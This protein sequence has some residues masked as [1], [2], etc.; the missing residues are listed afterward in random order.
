MTCSRKMHWIMTMLAI[1]MFLSAHILGSQN[2]PVIR[3]SVENTASHVQTQ[4]VQRFS[5]A[6]RE[7]LAGSYDV[8]F[9]PAA[10]LFRDADVFRAL[11]Q[12]KV[13]IA[14]PG[15]WQ[16]DRYVPEVGLFLLPSMY[17]RAA[18]VTYGLMESS[19]G[20]QVVSTI[21]RVM[22]VKVLGRWIDLGHTHVFSTGRSITKA[23]DFAGKRI[24]VAGGVGNSLR[25]EA[26]GATPTTIA[27]PDFPAALTRKSVDGVLTSYE[28]IAS[29]RLWERGIDA[30][31]ED[32]QY[33]AQYVPI[34][35]GLFWDRL[36][37]DVQDTI[38]ETWDELVDRARQE[39]TVAQ[40]QSRSL[41]IRNGVS[42]TMVS[43]DYV[44]RTRERLMQQEESMV[45][46]MGISQDIYQEFKQFIQQNSTPFIGYAL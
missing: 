45:I 18:S 13:E 38:M 30:V 40:A 22:D 46:T 19:V 41:M 42:I 33:F 11:A 25:I 10:S 23:D 21:E 36:P 5:E 32:K 12:G 20:A 1:F 29:A 31:Y 9:Y 6:L 39:A 34:A 4:A 28:T 14:V 44:Q 37:I 2:L 16:F 17:G 15:T 35:S 3:I 24:R 7:H 27:W 8:E 26:L 43:N